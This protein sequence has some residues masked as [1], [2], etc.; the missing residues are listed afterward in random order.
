MSTTGRPRSA[1]ERRM[2]WRISAGSAYGRRP[3]AR[4][5]AQQPDAVQRAGR[6]AV[7]GVE[8]VREAELVDRDRHPGRDR[9][10]HAAAL[11]RQR[12]PRAVVA[13]AGRAAAQQLLTA[14]GVAHALSDSSAARR[15]AGISVGRRLAR[16]TKTCTNQP[17]AASSS[18]PRSRRPIS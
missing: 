11:D 4:V 12:Q 6:R 14:C 1:F 17:S 16:S 3:S 8:G 7:D 2:Y 5:A 15:R 18:V 13:L 10:A 9:A